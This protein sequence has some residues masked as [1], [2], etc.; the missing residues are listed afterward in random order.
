MPFA[1]SSR[2]ENRVGTLSGAN[3]ITLIAANM[4]AGYKQPVPVGVARLDYWER[5]LEIQA[6]SCPRLSGRNPR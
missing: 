2:A 5:A 3:E 6:V 4:A 1:T